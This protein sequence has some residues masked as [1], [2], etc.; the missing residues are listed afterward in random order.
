[1]SVPLELF[2]A[3]PKHTEVADWAHSAW[4]IVFVQHFLA[5]PRAF[6]PV[7]PGLAR[8]PPCHGLWLQSRWTPAAAMQCPARHRLTRKARMRWQ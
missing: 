2:F 6:T 7:N 3:A 5:S 1:M 4:L 8:L